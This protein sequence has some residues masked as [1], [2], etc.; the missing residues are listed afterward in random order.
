M[1]ENDKEA[2]RISQSSVRSCEVE[3]IFVFPGVLPEEGHFPF[4]QAGRSL[5]LCS[6]GPVSASSTYMVMS[7]RHVAQCCVLVVLPESVSHGAVPF[8][9]GA[10]R[11]P[12]GSAPFSWERN[13]R[14]T[15]GY[16]LHFGVLLA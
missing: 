7:S 8:L 2:E 4:T 6:E 5:G 16:I 12:A 1:V 10:K 13:Q 14:Q 3:C 9:V 11:G 15:Y